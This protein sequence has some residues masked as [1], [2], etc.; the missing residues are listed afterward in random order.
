[1]SAV[2]VITTHGEIQVCENDH[3][4]HDPDL[5]TVPRDMTIVTLNAVTPKIPNMLPSKNVGPFVRI[6]RE[7]TTPDLFNAGSTRESMISIVEEIK[8]RILEQDDQVRFISEN[9]RSKN[10]SFTSDEET[11]SY[12]YHPDLLYEIRSYGSGEQMYNKKFLRELSD[13]KGRSS[14]WKLS[15]LNTG[16]TTDEDLMDTL[17]PRIA[18][19]RPSTTRRTENTITRTENIIDELH[20]RGIRKLIIIDLSCNV[21][22]RGLYGISATAERHLAFTHSKSRKGGKKNKTRKLKLKK[23]TKRARRGTLFRGK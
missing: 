6:V 5:Y 23:K 8:E 13:V 16:V 4:T 7:N 15:L 11:M 2:L 22:R 19:L 21:I 12:F 9:V 14:D 3:G 17:N 10:E 1:M 20:G 18:A